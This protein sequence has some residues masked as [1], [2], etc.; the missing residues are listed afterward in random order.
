[1]KLKGTISV[2]GNDYRVSLSEKYLMKYSDSNYMTIGGVGQIIRQV[3]KQ[4]LTYDNIWV[5]TES[6]AGGN[7][8]NVYLENVDY[9]EVAKSI[10]RSFQQ[11]TFNGMIDM[12]EYFGDTKYLYLDNGNAVI[13][14][15][16]FVSVY[17]TIPWDIEMKRKE[18]A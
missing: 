9:I 7:S 4:E 10:G 11:G 18:V 16:K 13:C 1:M 3:L 12:Y 5:R 14:D 2:N 6:Y 15:S 8:V 17:D